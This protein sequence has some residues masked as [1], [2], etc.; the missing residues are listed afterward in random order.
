VRVER[1][2]AHV[3]AQEVF[4]GGDDDLAAVGGGGV[5]LGGVCELSDFAVGT[6][7]CDGVVESC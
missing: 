5:G 2:G 6:V 4:E 7:C 3:H 1:V